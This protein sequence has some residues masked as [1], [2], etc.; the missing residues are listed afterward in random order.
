MSLKF[1]PSAYSWNVGLFYL[2][3]LRGNAKSN[4]TPRTSAHRDIA[5]S[6]FRRGRFF[7][8]LPV[9]IPSP[10][11]A[12]YQVRA[13][14]GH[15]QAEIGPSAGGPSECLPRRLGLPPL[16][17]SSSFDTGCAPVWTS[18]AISYSVPPCPLSGFN[19]CSFAIFFQTRRVLRYSSPF[20]EWGSHQLL[21]PSKPR[22]LSRRYEHVSRRALSVRFPYGVIVAH[23]CN[24]ALT[25]ALFLL[26]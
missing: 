20:V 26:G 22:L 24:I 23:T 13:Q 9:S 4:K 25:D 12:V 21:T 6:V 18:T 8:P 17:F 14:Q 7:H 15:A 16:L 1:K 2:N 11:E 19:S 3:L 10:S 5:T